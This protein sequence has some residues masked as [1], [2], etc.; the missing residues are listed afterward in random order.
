M[1]KSRIFN[2]RKASEKILNDLKNKIIKNALSP[3]LAVVLVGDDPASKIYVKKKKEASEI[4]GI[5][6]EEYKFSEK[7]SE[8]LIIEKIKD[9]NEDSSVHGIIVQ[10]PLP[11]KFKQNKIMS[12]IDSKKDVDGFHNENLL[13][14]K[15]NKKP[16]FFPVLPSVIYFLIKKAVK[17]IKKK[18]IIAIVNSDIF[19]E[20]L[21]YFF[22]KE[23]IRIKSFLRKE[24]NF[25]KLK[26]ADVIISVCGF[27]NMIRGEM[28]KSGSVLIDAGFSRNKAGKIV[29]DMDM[30]SVKEKAGFITP[31]P[32]GVGPLTIAFLLK[33]VYL[34]S[35]KAKNKK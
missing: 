20:N 17:D 9:L 10:L 8:Q 3:K 34:S 16:Y 4:I 7:D 33:N 27:P 14:L 21:E 1:V 5:S 6:L 26:K 22:K 13:L 35:L 29:G 32:G 2:G 18:N 12:S 11:K 31:V 30:E 23:G 19:S 28:I 25:S 15:K 24:I